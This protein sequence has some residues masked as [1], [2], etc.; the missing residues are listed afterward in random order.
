MVSYREWA[1]LL[2]ANLNSLPLDYV[3]RQK[4]QGQH[5]N[6]YI[7]EQ[8]P[9]ISEVQFRNLVGQRSIGDMVREEV[10]R[11]TYTAHDMAPFARDQGYGGP[12]LPWDEEDRLRQ[13]AR[14]DALFFLLYGLDSDETGYVLDQF[15]IVRRQEEAAFGRYRSRDLILGYLAAFRAND[16][17]AVIAA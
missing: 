8:L 9:V 13:R 10:L 15:R 4:V 5:L 1:P 16:P 11:L 6:W 7:V 12:P 14:L 17:E 2:L 3:A